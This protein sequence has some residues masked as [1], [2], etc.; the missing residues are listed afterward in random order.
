MKWYGAL[1]VWWMECLHGV[2]EAQGYRIYLFA[3]GEAFEMKRYEE[4]EASVAF[5]LSSVLGLVDL[6]VEHPVLL[7]WVL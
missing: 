6:I 5:L 3:R 1:T 4:T 7:W 2:R